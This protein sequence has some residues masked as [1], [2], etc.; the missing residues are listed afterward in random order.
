MSNVAPEQVE[1][2]AA[3]GYSLPDVAR[4][5]GVPFFSQ[6]SPE[7]NSAIEAFNRGAARWR[8]NGQPLPGRVADIIAQAVHS[9][10]LAKE[11]TRP[12]LKEALGFGYDDLNLAIETLE[13]QFLID[14]EEDGGG[15][16]YYRAAG[17]VSTIAQKRKEIQPQNAAVTRESF[18]EALE[19]VSRP[20]A[21]NKDVNEP[22]QPA[23]ISNGDGDLAGNKPEKISARSET[24]RVEEAVPEK[25][26]CGRDKKHTGRC[27]FR[28]R[29]TGGDFPESTRKEKTGGRPRDPRVVIDLVHIENL[30]AEGKTLKEVAAAINMNYWTF[31]D[32]RYQEKDL[33]SALDRGHRRYRDRKPNK[34]GGIVKTD[35]PL[36]E[37]GPGAMRSQVV[38]VVAETNK[39]QETL[40]VKLTPQQFIERFN[41]FDDGE[42]DEFFTKLN[43][44]STDDNIVWGCIAG[45]TKHSK[46]F[47]SVAYNVLVTLLD[48]GMSTDQKQSVWTLICYMKRLQK[49]GFGG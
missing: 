29:M 5:L 40:P 25:C 26:G 17:T 20:T 47:F 24:P 12:E 13:L 14:H 41:S 10:L 11:M 44:Q 23:P 9:H 42:I 38:D 16:L 46:Q 2:H 32:R 28:R 22:S 37:S 15:T 19:T 6:N 3:Q 30:R 7:S 33:Q 31:F 1:A 35:L 43:E 48:D 27:S 45:R 39:D 36:S 4:L 21:G 49:D 34:R 18:I 8:D